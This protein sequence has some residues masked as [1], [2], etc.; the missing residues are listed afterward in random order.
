MEFRNCREIKATPLFE[1]VTMKVV[2]DG[3]TAEV[4]REYAQTYKTTASEVVRV[5]IAMV[6]QEIRESI[7]EGGGEKM[8]EDI[9]M[10]GAEKK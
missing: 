7:R 2:V 3:K 5:G 1:P 8:I 4:L 9:V 6:I 10:Q